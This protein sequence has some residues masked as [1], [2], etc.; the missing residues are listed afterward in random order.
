M[1]APDAELKINGNL[2]VS[3]P[4]Q[5][6]SSSVFTGV[7]AERFGAINVGGDLAITSTMKMDPKYI[8][9]ETSE[10]FGLYSEGGIIKVAG[11][12]KVAL[13]FDYTPHKMADGEEIN[14]VG[15]Y[16]EIDTDH[17]ENPEEDVWVGSIIVGGNVDSQVRVKGDVSL[18]ASLLAGGDHPDL[19]V[20]KLGNKNSTLNFSTFHEGQGRAYGVYFEDNIAGDGTSLTGATV[21]ISVT[22]TTSSDP[23]TAFS[24][25]GG[26][27]KDNK[28]SDTIFRIN[29]DQLNITSNAV[30]ANARAIEFN[31]GKLVVG[32]NDSSV[33]NI[34]ALSDKG[35]SEA[36]FLEGEASLLHIRGNSTLTGDVSLNAGNLVLSGTSTIK[37]NLYL[38]PNSTLYVGVGGEGYEIKIPSN[39]PNN[40]LIKV[41]LEGGP[42]SLLI[43]GGAS[44]I[45]EAGGKII[46][47]ES[48]SYITNFNDAVLSNGVLNPLYVDTTHFK[49]EDHSFFILN[50]ESLKSK[51]FDTFRQLMVNYNGRVTPGLTGSVI[52]DENLV[53]DSGSGSLSVGNVS[54]TNSAISVEVKQNES[55]LITGSGD[56]INAESGDVDISVTNGSLNVGGNESTGGT[57]SG[58]I[59]ATDGSSIL[60]DG[61]DSSIIKNYSVSGNVSL[62]DNSEMAVHGNAQVQ[63]QNLM[64]EKGS[65]VRV[66]QSTASGV[67]H[68]VVNGTLDL[69]GKFFTDPTW[70]NKTPSK[71]IVKELKLTNGGSFIVGQN[72][73][74]TIGANTDLATSQLVASGHALSKEGVTAALYITS[75]IDVAQGSLVVDGSLTQVPASTTD[76]TVNVASNG[77]LGIALSDAT[78]TGKEQVFANGSLV[79]ADNSYLYLNTEAVTTNE[80]LN[81]ILADEVKQDGTVNIKGSSGLWFGYKLTD[82]VLSAQ[83]DPTSV[84]LASGLTAPEVTRELLLT[85]KET[86]ATVT[87]RGMISDG[88]YAE[89]AAYMNRFA[90][91]ANAG[92]A[93]VMAFNAVNL[94]NNAVEGHGSVLAAYAHERQG[95]DLWIDVNGFFSKAN[96]YESGKTSYG[97]RADLAGTTFG[98]D[99]SFGNNVAAGAAVSIGK[100]NSRGRG[101][102]SGVKNRFD[103]WGVNLY[104]VWATPYANLV[105]NVGFLQSKNKIEGHGL[106]GKPDVNT[107]SLGIKAEKSF[108]V[109]DNF[110]V[111]PHV[112]VRYMNI[113]MKRFNAG[114]FSYSAEKANLVQFPVGVAFNTEAKTSFGVRIKPV[115]DLEI[116]PTAGDRKVKNKFGLVGTGASDTLDTRV[117]NNALYSARLSVQADKGGHTFGLGYRFSGGNDGRVDQTLQAKYRYSF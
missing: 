57:I 80:N 18:V 16:N 19:L 65:T 69:Q 46:I 67:G 50:D 94:V 6:L 35:K 115:L 56:L 117:A 102:G 1:V 85:N 47:T 13:D 112:G 74:G 33:I 99:Y 89:A 24:A 10:A 9:G 2:T 54:L 116:A 40:P 26:V 58:N 42:G 106:K 105:G 77:W 48:S 113:D 93:H 60:F 5:G 25:K 111:T 114:G 83:Y 8:P 64:V 109:T 30:N 110:A 23:V 84:L 96:K 51:D 22:S 92:A 21:N 53:V 70:E 49:F 39:R 87:L 66:G 15:I 29:S 79:L 4:N 107:F 88:S 37:G 82:N 90:S 104:S 34:S 52:Y 62:N 27:V 73:V 36:V 20:T 91:F 97:Y 17:S 43:E 44:A 38:N 11:D 45:K 68:L 76:G 61:K 71:G 98:A 103:Y 101:V 86:A 55:L 75:P 63:T 78:A 108:A 7:Y 59:V 100:G 28:F 12:A 32:N 95:L 72:S 81:V 31:G 41:K 3:V 14:V